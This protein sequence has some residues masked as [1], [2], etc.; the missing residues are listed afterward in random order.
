M[1]GYVARLY[2]WRP[3]HTSDVQPV[4]ADESH[5]FYAPSDSGPT[6]SSCTSEQP[7]F[8]N[9]GPVP[10]VSAPCSPCAPDKIRPP[11]KLTA[12]FSE[13]RTAP[14]N[15]IY[16]T[17]KGVAA[18]ALIYTGAAV[19]VLNECICH[20]RCEV[21]TPLGGL[22][23]WAA[24]AQE[25]KSLAMCTASVLIQAITYVIE[26]TLLLTYSHNIIL[27]WDFLSCHHAA[28]DCAGA[29]VELLLL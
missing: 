3:P 5:P 2:C 11:R 29:H 16:T 27:R 20:S 7:P 18:I 25:V 12:A 19:S 10:R 26:F 17:V 21:T 6:P 23:F 13:A 4:S 1:P 15:V 14:A 28:I 22:T 8:S 9:L 24:S